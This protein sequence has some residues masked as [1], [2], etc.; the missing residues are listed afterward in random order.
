MQVLQT[1]LQSKHSHAS[2]LHPLVCT[3]FP[4]QK[5]MRKEKKTCRE[6]ANVHVSE[7]VRLQWWANSAFTDGTKEKQTWKQTN[8]SWGKATHFTYRFC[9]VKP[10]SKSDFVISKVSVKTESSA[11]ILTHISANSSDKPSFRALGRVGA[12]D[13]ARLCERELHPP[14]APVFPGH[15]IRNPPAESDSWHRHGNRKE[16]C[17]MF[18]SQPTSCKE[19][20]R[21]PRQG[22]RFF[23]TPK[24]PLAWCFHL[25]LAVNSISLPR[26]GGKRG[27]DLSRKSAPHYPSHRFLHPSFSQKEKK[28]GKNQELLDHM[29]KRYIYS[30]HP[31]FLCSIPFLLTGTPSQR[32]SKMEQ[33]KRIERTCPQKYFSGFLLNLGDFYVSISKWGFGWSCLLFKR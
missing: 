7:S 12:A 5:L 22:S 10:N 19:T 25:K 27:E 17:E 30:P 2:P 20:P 32:K 31:D 6:L 29:I 24:K 28:T 9:R 11:L 16:S 1:E 15:V 3:D 4:E 33:S 13:S 14:L 26:G 21:L 23:P 18:G 8:F